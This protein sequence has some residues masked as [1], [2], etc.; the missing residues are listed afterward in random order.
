MTQSLESDIRTPKYFRC[1]CPSTK[2][3]SY[4]RVSL[5]LESAPPM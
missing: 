4:T 2:L 3:N 5:V 1:R